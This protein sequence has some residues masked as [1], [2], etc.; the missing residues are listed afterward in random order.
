[1]AGCTQTVDI[2]GNFS[3]PEEIDISV[4]QGTILG[5]L[6]FLVYINDLPNATDL[7]SFLYA[8]DTTALDFDLD[9]STLINRVNA[10]L[11]KLSNWFKSNRMALNVSKTKYIIF[12]LP[13]KKITSNMSLYFDEN[14]ENLPFNPELVMQIERIHT[15]NPNAN[16]RSFKLLGILLDENLNFN[17]NT[18]ALSNKL[19]RAIFFIN[20]VKNLLSAKALKTLYT[21]F[22]HSHLLYCPII[23]SCTSKSNL[24]KLFLLQKKQLELCLVPNLETILILFSKT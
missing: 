8:D 15:N 20:R 2:D 24:N 13:S 11:K 3:D 5:P 21:S 1:M 12:H 16:A 7:L 9:L 22:F 14:E 4:L 6:L 18:L 23:Y 19:S 10:E 17:A